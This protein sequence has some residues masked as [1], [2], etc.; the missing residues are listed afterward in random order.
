MIIRE[1]PGSRTTFI[2]AD[3]KGDGKTARVGKQ[4][5]LELKQAAPA[6]FDFIEPMKAVPVTD[7]IAALDDQGR[8]SFQL[9]QSYG[10]AKKTPLV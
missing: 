3:D 10:K 5:S 2:G 9:L 6:T 1:V 4:H 7:E 8:A